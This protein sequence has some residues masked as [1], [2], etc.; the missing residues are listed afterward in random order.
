MNLFY[1]TLTVCGALS[2]SM[3]ALVV[4]VVLWSS[5]PA[6]SKSCAPSSTIHV[7]KRN[8]RRRV[9]RV[10]DHAIA[11][12]DGDEWVSFRDEEYRFALVLI[13]SLV[14]AGKLGVAEGEEMRREVCNWVLGQKVE[15]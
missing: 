7:P 11:I 6:R 12:W 1:W 9:A 15:V 3:T 5:L 14:D 4:G 2:L 13:R 8:P 10:H